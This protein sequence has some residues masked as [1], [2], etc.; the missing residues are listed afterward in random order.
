MTQQ[1]GGPDTLTFGGYD[2]A[3]IGSLGLR[4]L[5]ASRVAP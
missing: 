4:T 2:G 1:Q 5:V 3:S